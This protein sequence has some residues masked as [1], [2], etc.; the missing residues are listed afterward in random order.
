[1]AA[2]YSHDPFSFSIPVHIPTGEPNSTRVFAILGGFGPDSGSGSGGG[3]VA[4]AEVFSVF[5]DSHGWPTR[6]SRILVGALDCGVPGGPNACGRLAAIG[7]RGDAQAAS[8]RAR[9]AYCDVNGNYVPDRYADGQFHII[10]N[11]RG[12][13]DFVVPLAD[14][15]PERIGFLWQ[16]QLPI[17]APTGNPLRDTYVALSF[18]AFNGAINGDLPALG[19]YN[20]AVGVLNGLAQLKDNPDPIAG[21]A[22]GINAA[23]SLAVSLL[24]ASTH[25]NFYWLANILGGDVNAV[26]PASPS[27]SPPATP[28]GQQPPPPGGSG[29][30]AGGG[31]GGLRGNLYI[32]PSGVVETRSGVPVAGATVSLTR[33][34]TRS[35]A[36]RRLPAGSSTMAPENRRN[37]DRTGLS[38]AFGWDVLPGYYQVTARRRGCH[39]S[40]RTRVLAIPPPFTN[41]RLRLRCPGLHR[42]KTR[43]RLAVRREGPGTTVLRATVTK[44]GRGRS[45]AAGRTLTGTV[46]F[47]IGRTTLSS[48][49]LDPRTGSAVLTVPRLKLH[50]RFTAVY[51]G[52]ALFAPSRR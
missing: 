4:G 48:T 22:Q 35:G 21:N 15:S 11:D 6:M 46:T 37:P 47:R 14:G 40:A 31:R 50:G 1:L 32:D 36:Q 24:N 27:T 49:A 38:G 28:C 34:D 51:S 43:V 18:G 39:G 29:G 3:D 30:G 12:G 9:A 13:I 20:T 2:V 19:Y 42:T 10:P 25:G 23:A 45:R 5:Y 26:L 33:S 41:L 7:V 8:V 17:P 44:A 16:A 52:N